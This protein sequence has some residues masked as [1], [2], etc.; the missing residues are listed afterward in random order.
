MS[1]EEG[2]DSQVQKRHGDLEEADDT[3]SEG[4]TLPPTQEA[5]THQTV[6]KSTPADNEPESNECKSKLDDG[7]SADGD[8]S[9]GKTSDEFR[10]STSKICYIPKRMVVTAMLGLGMLLVYAM[11][12]NVGVT[13]VMILHERAFEKVGTLDA[14]AQVSTVLHTQSKVVLTKILSP[15]AK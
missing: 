2:S 8:L 15:N 3:Q 5:E 6:D 11:R 1:S 10:P 14:S 12:T 13:V 7:G 4:Q 9:N